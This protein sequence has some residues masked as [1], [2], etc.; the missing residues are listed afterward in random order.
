MVARVAFHHLLVYHY[1]CNTLPSL[2]I[3]AKVFRYFLCHFSF[4]SL[5]ILNILFDCYILR[6]DH[7]H[8]P[9]LLQQPSIN[10]PLHFHASPCPSPLNRVLDHMNNHCHKSLV[11]TNC[12]NLDNRAI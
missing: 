10:I 2:G 9:E 6:L 8:Y 3:R 5:L 1:D 4:P 7:L 11:P 12:Y